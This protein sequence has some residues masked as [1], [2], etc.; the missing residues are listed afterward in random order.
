[1]KL[2][3]ITEISWQNRWNKASFQGIAFASRVVAGPWGFV[4]GGAE[5]GVEGR[6]VFDLAYFANL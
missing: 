4:R 1:L 3:N 2:R 6:K 5:G